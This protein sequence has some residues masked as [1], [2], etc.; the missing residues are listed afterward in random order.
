MRKIDVRAVRTFGQAVFLRHDVSSF[1]AK[2]LRLGQIA[3]AKPGARHFFFVTRPDSARSRAN[4]FG[5]PGNFRRFVQFAVIGKN[6]VCAVADVQPPVYIYARFRKCFN[7]RHQ[8][9]GIHYHAGA[10]DCVLLWPQNTAWNE[11]QN[12]T[13][14]SD[15]NRVPGVVA[16]S[17]ARD[18]VERAGEIVDDFALAFITPLRA[19][20]DDGLHSIPFSS[21]FPRLPGTATVFQ[22]RTLPPPRLPARKYDWW[23]I[24]EQPLESYAGLACNA[25][26]VS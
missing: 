3:Q 15:D 5:P 20:H 10:N 25:S 21:H 16:P 9:A 2:Q 18:V 7:L 6:Q 13:V 11:L 22:G 23:E 8:R 14:F 1:F 26:K 12:E 4:L 19:H 24:A 17:N